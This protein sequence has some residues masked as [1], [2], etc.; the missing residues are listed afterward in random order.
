MA[1]EREG[2]PRGDDVRVAL[3]RGA[4]VGGELP[5]ATRLMA[6]SGTTD[7][8]A[9]LGGRR[10]VAEATMLASAERVPR[11]RKAVRDDATAVLEM[12]ALAASVEAHADE[13]RLEARARAR[14]LEAIEELAIGAAPPL[15]ALAAP[16]VAALPAGDDAEAEEA[17]R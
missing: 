3:A 7:D 6:E 8:S 12:E 11:L 16:R 13:A 4:G 14:A 9:A 17:C 2:G 15:E 1:T 10:A 5:T